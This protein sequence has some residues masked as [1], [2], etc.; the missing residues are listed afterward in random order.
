MKIG[1]FSEHFNLPIETVRYYINKGLLIP[2]VK[3]ARY[4]FALK[5]IEDMELIIRLKTFRFSLHDIHRI[6]SLKRLSNLDNSDELNDYL[7]I[8]N[9]QKNILETEKEKFESA[10]SLLGEEIYQIS[11]R[12][13]TGSGKNS[14]VALEFLNYLSC[15]V[16][17]NSLS[18]E[19]CSIENQEIYSGI[20]KCK[21]GYHALI[22]DG[23]LIG[24][25][26]DSERYDG[27]DTDRNC[28]RMMSPELISNVQKAYIDISEKLK[29]IPTDGK[30]ILEDFV[31]NYCFCYNNLSDLNPNALY[32]ISDQYMEVVRL[33]KDLIDKLSLPH[34]IL[35]ISASSHLLPLKEQCVHVYI[36]FDSANEYAIFNNGYASDAVKKY[37]SAAA[38]ILGAFFSFPKNCASVRELHLQFPLA[39]D[40][41]FDWNRFQKHFNLIQKEMV[42]KNQVGIVTN[43]G[44]GESFSYHQNDEPLYLNTYMCK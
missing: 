38:I 23:I 9:S 17:K 26:V 1:E 41:C 12:K 24:Q 14:G 25:T 28:Y 21:C 22:Q 5:D 15:P 10:L 42:Y 4:T 34:R 27:A 39:C 16:C 40:D 19:N 7:S 29:D 43:S 13:N 11:S 2:H 3:N 35:F 8:M 20:L 37:F 44:V 33:Y 32:I 6:I 31:N 36:D 18:L 30:V